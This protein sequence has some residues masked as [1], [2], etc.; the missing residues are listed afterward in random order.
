MPAATK[1]TRR[2]SRAVQVPREP[3]GGVP[4]CLLGGD[5]TGAAV[6]ADHDL[7]FAVLAREGKRRVSDREADMAPGGPARRSL[8]SHQRRDLADAE[9]VPVRFV[10][11]R[12]DRPEHL[13]SK[14]ARKQL[15]SKLGSERLCDLA[16]CRD[17]AAGTT[18]PGEGR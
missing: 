8:P 6:C 5:G 16:R 14:A 15:A 10:P 2:S 12:L 17:A 3:P 1:L 4:E 18:R 11:V 13:L 9:L 7:S